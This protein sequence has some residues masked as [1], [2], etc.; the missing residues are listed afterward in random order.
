MKIKTFVGK[1]QL[2]NWFKGTIFLIIGVLNSRFDVG[3]NWFID[4]LILGPT[5]YFLVIVS[6]ILLVL[7]LKSPQESTERKLNKNKVIK[8]I[9]IVIFLVAYGISAVYVFYFDRNIFVLIILGIIGVF[10][11]F[12][13]LYGNQWEEKSILIN[14]IISFLVS[15][16]LIYGAIL[17]NVSVPIYVYFFF[18]GVFTLQFSKDILKSCKKTA[19]KRTNTEEYKLFAEIVTIKKA[20]HIVLLLQ[21]LTILFLVIPF[22]TGIYNSFLYLIPMIIGA[23]L[24]GIAAIL[25]YLYN[26]EEE[27]KGRVFI[28]LRS[29]M[30]C[31]IIAYFF[32]SI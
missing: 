17:N 14:V 2:I 27:Y 20:Q 24:I 21:I 30:L 6:G 28:L 29:G 25:N 3:Y 7:F 5:L 18:M 10:W 8:I 16:G 11:G 4:N 26:F 31:I 9:S 1:Y 15:F 12:S 32:A 13:F 22:I 19:E 23:I